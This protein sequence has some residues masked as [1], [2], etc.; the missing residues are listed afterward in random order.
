MKLKIYKNIFSDSDLKVIQNY[1]D[2]YY[3]SQNYRKNKNWNSTIIQ[4]SKPVLIH[5]IKNN[6]LLSLIKNKLVEIGINQEPKGMM[7]Y[8][9]KEGSYIPWHTDKSHSA[10]LTIYLNN[11]WYYSN[12][13]LFLYAIDDKIKTII[14]KKNLGV[15][16]TGGVPHSTTI[17][18]ENKVRKTLQ[19]F[20]KESKTKVKKSII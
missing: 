1:S 8:Y 4:N 5:D 16:Q 13:G 10:G 11:E 6:Y 15:F 2:E 19:L 12:G 18:S 7:F 9:W 20:F 14:P 17:V 3:K